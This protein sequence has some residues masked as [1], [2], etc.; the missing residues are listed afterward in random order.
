M[1][2]AQVEVFAPL[3]KG[4][5]RDDLLITAIE[6]GPLRQS[7]FYAHIWAPVRNLINGLDA[8]PIPDPDKPIKYRRDRGLDYTRPLNPPLGKWPRVHD[9]RHSHASWMLEQGLSFHVLQYRLGHESIATTVDRYGHLPPT[10]QGE[11][12]QALDRAMVDLV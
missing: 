6:G 10:S 9:L 8:Y 1:T 4:K 2:D 11:A 5:G 12:R 7:K 3:L